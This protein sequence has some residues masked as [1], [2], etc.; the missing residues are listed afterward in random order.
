MGRTPGLPTFLSDG[1]ERENVD[2]VIVVN[3]HLVELLSE[4]D[5]ISEGFGEGG[6]GQEDLPSSL[7]E[8]Q[9]IDVGKSGEEEGQTRG[10]RGGKEF[11]GDQ[12]IRRKS[13]K[14]GGF[15][16]GQV[17]PEAIDLNEIV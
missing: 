3:G 5:H 12:G 4:Q 8:S 14:Q 16:G 9:L 17:D 15:Y 10:G 11:E 6:A 13:D 2:V 7:E 1:A